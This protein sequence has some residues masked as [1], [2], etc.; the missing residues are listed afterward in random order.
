MKYFRTRVRFPP[1]P[2]VGLLDL[3]FPKICLGCGRGGRYLCDDCLSKLRLLKPVCPYC[4]RPSIDGFTH[5]K[6]R[7]V[8]GLD[9][10]ASIWGYEGAIKKA[11]MALKYK[12]STEV[13]QELA[14]SF[15]RELLQVGNPIKGV[16][17]PIPI[18]WHRE[19]VRGFNQSEEIGNQVARQMGWEFNPDLLVK[20]K[21]TP[22]QV[23]LSVEKRKQ[24]LKGVFALDSRFQIP[25]SAILFDDVFTTGSTLNE[26]AK[27]L[28][29]AGVGKVWGLT[30]AR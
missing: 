8:Y 14:I 11:I 2:P 10:L 25:D 29:R 3:V 12:Y 7:K 22:S 30:I 28:K 27:V 5:T 4:E 15:V 18:H 24:N 23:E 9:G 6:C 20:A 19:N 16:L 13:G 17:V 1:S 21:P 26:A